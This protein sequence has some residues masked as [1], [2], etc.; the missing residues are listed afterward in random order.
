MQNVK[1]AEMFAREKHSGMTRK[2]GVTPY[3]DHLR[4]VVDRLKN[5]GISDVEVLS[6]A[7][8]HD[9]LEDTNTNF[10]EIDQR[11]GS[12][13]AVLVLSLSKDKNLPRGQQEKQ[14][15]KQLK[16]ASFEAK[17]IKLCDIS[18]NLKDLKDAWW[19]RTKKTKQ[20]KKKMHY[21][22]VI[23]PDLIQNK[24]NFPGIQSIIDGI[25]EVVISYGQQPIVL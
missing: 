23:K 4:G 18:S 8:L 17:L 16:E 12:K 6:A 20:V 3:F 7:W 14:Y 13:V 11:F 2:D 22:N 21:L 19:S 15:V 1:A 24:F 25:N 10:D 9:T 5:L